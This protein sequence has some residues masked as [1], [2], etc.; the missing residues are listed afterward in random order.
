M[1]PIFKICQHFETGATLTEQGKIEKETLF[2]LFG[3]VEN[4]VKMTRVSNQYRA[5]SSFFSWIHFIHFFFSS[6]NS[7][8]SFILS[9]RFTIYR[10]ADER[11]RFIF[12]FLNVLLL[13]FFLSHWTCTHR[14]SFIS[15]TKDVSVKMLV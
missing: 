14:S 4:G 11:L 15:G 13:L 6:P 1:Y 8:L 3:M 10:W 12:Y 5:A 2:Y 9:L 7:I